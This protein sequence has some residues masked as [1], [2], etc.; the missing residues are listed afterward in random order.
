MKSISSVSDGAAETSITDIV[1][2]IIKITL[3][4]GATDVHLN[5]EGARMRIAGQIHDLPWHY[6]PQLWRQIL[7]RLKILA[8]I[9]TQYCPTP[10]DGKFNMEHAGRDYRITVNIFPANQSEKATLTILP[11]DNNTTIEDFNLE[12]QAASFLKAHLASR[13]GLIVIAGPAGSVKSVSFYAL[14][15]AARDSGKTRIIQTLEVAPG[16]HALPGIVQSQIV[17]GNGFGMENALYA[18]KRCHADVIGLDEVGDKKSFQFAVQFATS[19]LVILCM[20]SRTAQDAYETL[21]QYSPSPLLLEQ[22]LKGILIPEA[23]PLFCPACGRSDETPT[24]PVCGGVGVSGSAIVASYTA[25]ADKFTAANFLA[26]QAKA[27]HSLAVR[28]GWMK[29]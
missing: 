12:S 6:A 29:D 15:K 5:S 3:N 4:V 11:L 1:E 20:Q 26:A 28:A 25:S 13:S 14:L 22:N 24:C 19:Q 17:P 8:D 18:I 9:D 21:C 16:L 10:R 2:R 23:V 27:D 7:S